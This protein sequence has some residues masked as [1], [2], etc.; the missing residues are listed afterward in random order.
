M[1]GR[2]L[3]VVRPPLWRLEL[4]INCLCYIK[5]FYFLHAVRNIINLDHFYNTLITFTEKK[6]ERNM[7]IV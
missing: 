6:T 2:L 1:K 7:F 3:T 5:Y 4:E